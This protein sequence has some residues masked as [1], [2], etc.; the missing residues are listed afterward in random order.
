MVTKRLNE[1]VKKMF[2]EGLND[3]FLVK[4]A[5]ESTLGGVCEKST[6][7][8]DRGKHVDLWWNS[9]KKGVIGIDVKG[10]H[11]NKRTDKKYS[12]NHWVEAV[13][14][15]GNKG[16][17]YGEAKYI[18][19]KTMNEIM[20]VDPKDLIDIYE[21]KIADKELVYDTP[22]ECYIPYQR[23]KW[24][25]K[26]VMFKMPNDDLLKISKFIIEL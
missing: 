26:D 21:N 1:T 13:N 22:T 10:L 6:T 20:F 25:R 17:I 15:S 14:V 2:N 12:D 23:K 7:K 9:P 16:W 24:G 3:E 8:D 18:A 11:K 19:F 4:E 5:I